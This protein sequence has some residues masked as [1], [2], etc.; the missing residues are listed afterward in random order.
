MGSLGRIFPTESVMRRIAC[1]GLWVTVICAHGL[2]DFLFHT[3]HNNCANKE[4]FVLGTS[5]DFIMS[6]NGDKIRGI[7]DH[8]VLTN[9]SEQNFLDLELV[10]ENRKRVTGTKISNRLL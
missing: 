1:K 7:Q 4:E 10:G 2:P 9:R 6:L 3:V 8:L 5:Q